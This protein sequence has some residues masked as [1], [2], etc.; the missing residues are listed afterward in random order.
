LLEANKLFNEAVEHTLA[1]T[2]LSGAVETK[3][4]NEVEHYRV[5]ALDSAVHSRLEI[6]ENFKAFF[7]HDYAKYAQHKTV[8]KKLNSL[9]C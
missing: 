3:Y 5:K 8:K 2:V 9:V 7:E 6:V 4:M 1:Q